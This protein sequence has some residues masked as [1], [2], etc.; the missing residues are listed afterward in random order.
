MKTIL[1][2]GLLSLLIASCSSTPHALSPEHSEDKILSTMNDESKPGWVKDFE[3]E[4]FQVKDGKV[5]SLGIAELRG[6]DRLSAGFRVAESNAKRGVSSAIE[7]KLAYYFQ[8]SEENLD[9]D[10][11]SS[12]YVGSETS[13]LTTS[14]IRPHKRYWEKYATTTDEGERITR[15]R[16]Y[17][18]VSLPESQFKTQVLQAMR[19]AENKKNLSAEFRK[20]VQANWRKLLEQETP[21]TTASEQ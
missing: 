14:F 13:R 17:V 7:S 10:S 9:F 12:Q 4:P 18:T 16:V 11:Q 19:K 1:S 2:L 8:R 6:S 3:G 5:V 20:T 21:R 15:Y